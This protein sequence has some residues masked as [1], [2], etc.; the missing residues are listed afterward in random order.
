MLPIKKFSVL[1]LFIC[2]CIFSYSQPTITFLKSKTSVLSQKKGLYS[3]P[4]FDSDDCVYD[5]EV[6]GNQLIVS[7]ALLGEWKTELPKYN[8]R[9]EALFINQQ[10][11]KIVVFGVIDKKIF[12]AVG[13]DNEELSLH[14]SNILISN[15]SKLN[16]IYTKDHYTYQLFYKTSKNKSKQIIITIQN[17][18]NNCQINNNQ[19]TTNCPICAENK[20]SN[21]HRLTYLVTYSG[22]K[23]YYCS[24]YFCKLNKKNGEWTQESKKITQEFKKISPQERKKLKLKW[25]KYVETVKKSIRFYYYKISYY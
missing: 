9:C 17:V 14:Y 20:A 25:I 18:Q 7:E 1:C 2:S 15:S 3:L 24:K 22:T 6:A 13:Q 4:S 12:V 16:A 21:P 11:E 8:K 5:A 19:N 10:L 23:Q